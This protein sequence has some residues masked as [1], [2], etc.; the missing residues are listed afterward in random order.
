MPGFDKAS[1]DNDI[2]AVYMPTHS[3]HL[4]Q[5]LD[6]GCFGPLKRAYGGLIEQSMRLGYN[7]IDKFDFLKAYPTAH[8]EVLHLLIS[9]MAS[10]QLESIHLIKRGCLRSRISVYQPLTTPTPPHNKPCIN[11]LIL[12]CYTS[13]SSAITQASILSQEAPKTT[14][15]S[16][17][18]PSNLAVTAA[19]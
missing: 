4:L 2:I 16:P 7:Y 11:Q 3:L 19:Y 14:L 1:R 9:R 17:L 10:P 8:L 18:T 12:A 5:P 13:Y 6:A 15:L